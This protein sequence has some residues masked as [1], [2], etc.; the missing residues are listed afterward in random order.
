MFKQ[1]DAIILDRILYVITT[2]RVMMKKYI[3]STSWQQRVNCLYP[4]ILIHVWS[5]SEDFK[6]IVF[7]LMVLEKLWKSFNLKLNLKENFPAANL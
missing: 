6:N 3:F 5:S 7:H 1:T 4:I 2:G